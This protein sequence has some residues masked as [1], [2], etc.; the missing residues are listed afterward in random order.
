MNSI[1]LWIIKGLCVAALVACDP[2]TPNEA[3]NSDEFEGFTVYSFIPADPVG[4]VYLFHGTGGSANIAL[5][6]EVIDQTNELT[7]RGYGWVATESTER[8]GN[9]R[10]DVF[11]ASLAT[12]PDLARLSRLHDELIATTGTS[13]STPIFGIG[14]SNGARM[15][16]LFGQAFADGGYPVAAVAP[17][18][19]RAAPSVKVAGG[20]AVP[21]FWVTSVNDTVVP[22]GEVIS[23][24]QDS[25][26]LGTVT[27]LTNKA[28]EPLLPVRFTRIPTI[29][30][31]EAVGIYSL[32]YGTGAWDE[33]GNRVLDLETTLALIDALPLAAGT[34]TPRVQIERQI[35]AMLSVHQFVGLH[36][37]A[38]ADFFDAQIGRE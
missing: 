1:R 9:K 26:T 8:T 30:A 20:L 32:L 25:A 6:T 37:V 33:D 28:E 3:I 29:D 38:L 24:Q 11:D 34:G 36:R 17:F 2:V 5:R 16:T 14:M 31:E 23:D 21:G 27:Q 15:V 10:W 19:G 22:P 7:A 4:I 12:N 18:N 13:S 35:A